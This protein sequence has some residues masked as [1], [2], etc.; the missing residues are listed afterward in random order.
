MPS[1]RWD[2]FH[3][4]M[5]LRDRINQLFDDSMMR[6]RS[7]PME[8]YSA[9]TWSPPVDAWENEKEIV[10]T[11]EVPGVDVKEIDLRVEG[12][13]LSFKGVREVDPGLGQ[14]TFHRME[15]SY[16]AFFKSFVLPDSVDAKGI[17]AA[18]NAG[19][20]RVRLPK[21]KAGKGRTI[22]VK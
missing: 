13:S 20:L 19:V 2:L 4:L 8:L 12:D 17:T 9:G 10:L 16:G 5:T 1:S 7:L 6:G 21:R 11:A 18:C 22:E 3:D 15:R 14:G